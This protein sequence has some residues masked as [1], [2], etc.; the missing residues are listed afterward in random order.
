MR[1]KSGLYQVTERVYA[2][3]FNPGSATTFVQ[4]YV[5]FKLSGLAGTF[6]AVAT[7]TAFQ[8]FCTLFQYY[9]LAGLKV[10]FIPQCNTNNTIYNDN[11]AVLAVQQYNIP[12]LLT[13][14][15]PGSVMKAGGGQET[16]LQGYMLH[17]RV[18][19]H[20]G[21]RRV[22]VFVKPHLWMIS[23]INAEA[24]FDVNT[25][26]DMG[27]KWQLTTTDGNTLNNMTWG[28]VAFASNCGGSDMNVQAWDVYVTAYV[29]FKERIM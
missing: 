22:K 18:K 19:I 26:A 29:K 8:D 28:W 14:T 5:Q 3:C 23:Q 16:T 6:S 17:N 21:N 24:N 13:Y 1:S 10:E 15:D 27:T 7:S 25:N 2:G 9:K 12:Q 4:G 20:A 11:I